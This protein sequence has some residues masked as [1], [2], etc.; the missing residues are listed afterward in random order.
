VGV[1]Y[2]RIRAVI[3]KKV[4]VG[5]DDNFRLKGDGD[6]W[7][8][9]AATLYRVSDQLNLG[10]S[11]RSRMKTDV[12]GNAE[13]TPAGA[14]YGSGSTFIT[15]PDI[16]QFG[17]SYK[18]S[19]KVTINADLEYTW[20]STYDRLV[21]ESNNPL[22]NDIDEKQWDNTWVLRLGGQYKLSKDWAVRAGYIYDQSPV[23]E[24]YFETRVPDSDRQGI[25]VGAGH[26]VGNL[27]IDVAYMYL[28]FKNRTVNNS[29]A[30]DAAP[31]AEALD[32]NYKTTAH[33]A[34]IT[35]GYKF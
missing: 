33:L 17:A 19:E 15:L 30:D 1:N 28:K 21:I 9:N 6:G 23:P 20:W 5:V 13:L 32:G 2:V 7:G 11:Y 16:L 10:L 25:S 12:R 8:V 26:T 18:P 35:I 4:F 27:T 34:G 24:E 14:Q 31:A 29:T 22:F 3:E